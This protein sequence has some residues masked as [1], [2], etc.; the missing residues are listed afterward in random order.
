M[1][2]TPRLGATVGLLSLIPVAVF[3]LSRGEL[4]VGIALVNVLLI[5]GSLYVAFTPVNGHEPD[6][7]V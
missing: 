6:G 5:V 2:L 7:A 4:Y 1:E 3:A